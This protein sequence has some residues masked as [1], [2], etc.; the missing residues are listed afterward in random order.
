[1]LLWPFKLS[2]YELPLTKDGRIRRLSHFN[3]PS[4]IWVRDT[5][6]NYQ[7]TLNHLWALCEEYRKAYGKIHDAFRI[8]QFCVNRKDALDF[9]ARDWLSP[10][11]RCFSIYKEALDASTPDTVAAYRVFYW[12][13]KR[14]FARWPSADK[15]PQW[16]PDDPQKYIDKSFKCG[17]Y[18]P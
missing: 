4:S 12:L 15:V 11:S 8:W 13:D 7:W 17:K 18:T 16:W 2:S 5:S 9:G 1:M 14:E 3:H 10:F 6:A